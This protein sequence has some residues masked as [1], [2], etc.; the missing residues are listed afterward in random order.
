[1][2]WLLIDGNNWFAQC[3]FACPGGGVAN[4]CR[5]LETV[6]GQVEHSRAVVCWDG[7]NSWRREFCS[8]YKSQRAAKA[9]SFKSSLLK[10]QAAVAQIT[11]SLCVDAYEA[12]DLVA[13]LA[14]WAKG[15]GERA[16]LFSADKDLHQ[17]LES[18][19]TT[20]VTKVNRTSVKQCKFEV[21]TADRLF[22]SYGVKPWQWVDYRTIVGDKSDGIKGCHGCGEAA[23]LELLKVCKSLDAY[24]ENTNLRWKVK[25]SSRQ[26]TALDNFKDQ[27]GKKRK[28][29]T[30]CDNVPL[31]AKFY[32]GARA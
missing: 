24:Y 5:R 29:M 22:E 30:L 2:T 8:E 15:E 10:T 13:T 20:Q 21:M 19:Q 26:L 1:M 14:N 28:L 16:I 12:D 4:T 11:D 7:A 17:L 6:L 25:L 23:A 3:E 31:P 9:D 32:E 18:G 27:L